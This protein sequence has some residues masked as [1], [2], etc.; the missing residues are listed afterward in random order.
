MTI[1]VEPSADMRE[2]AHTVRE[3]YLAL[4]EQGFSEQQCCAIVGTMLGQAIA[5]GQAGDG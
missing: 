3:M 4:R 2:T 5:S 1:P